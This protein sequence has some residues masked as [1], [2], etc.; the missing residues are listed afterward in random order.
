MTQHTDLPTDPATIETTVPTNDLLVHRAWVRSVARALLGDTPDADDLEQDT[1][2][3]ALR[4][5]PGETRSPRA[6][7]ATVVRNRFRDT[8]RT[9][10][11]RTAREAAV[12]R[13]EAVPS[14]AELA[15]R[16]DE[17]RRVV[18]AVL[19]L[20]ESQRY[21]VLLR[22][23]EGLQPKEIGERLCV[24]ASTVRSR[25]ARAHARLRELLDAEH[26]GDGRSWRRALLPL[27]LPAAGVEADPPRR[28]TR[29][30]AAAV[31]IV[32]AVLLVLGGVAVSLWSSRS[33]AG[34][35]GDDAASTDT[36]PREATD[37]DRP[38]GRARAAGAGPQGDRVGNGGV[39]DVAPE[40]G[41]LSPVD[42]DGSP[43]NEAVVVP[44]DR[45]LHVLVVQDGRPVEG[46]GVDVLHADGRD[47][48][49]ETVLARGITDTEGAVT[50]ERPEGRVREAR[51]VARGNGR[52]AVGPIVVLWDP[53]AATWTLELEAAMELRGLVSDS[54]GV[55]IASA[56]MQLRLAGDRGRVGGLATTGDAEGRFAF[57]LLPRTVLDGATLEIAAEGYVT[58]WTM[59]GERDLQHALFDVTLAPEF[60]VVGRCVDDEGRPVEDAQ[61]SSVYTMD[62]ARSGPDGRF[63]LTKLERLGVPLL[64]EHDAHATAMYRAGAGIRARA[65][66]DRTADLGDVVLSSGVDAVARAVTDDGEPVA[67]AQI[68]LHSIR[69]GQIVA[70]GTTGEDGRVT[71]SHI[72][73]TEHRIVATAHGDAG[74]VGGRQGGISGWTPDGEEVVV[75][76]DGHRSLV[77][78]LVDAETGDPIA[79]SDVSLQI[80]LASTQRDVEHVSWIEDGV[81]IV[82]HRLA[83]S[84]IYAVVVTAT[85][86]EPVRLSDVDIRSDRETVVRARLRAAGE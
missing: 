57:P 61:I 10:S 15:S 1:W 84:G 4:G 2:L 18:R 86:Y 22:W 78:H 56:R 29:W 70:Q 45:S 81:R 68:V 21:I 24:P 73:R 66:A 53:T 79:V 27:L 19:A 43:S 71:L 41:G 55:A 23:F 39:D 72:A 58:A 49:A 17:H 82:R 85:G 12:A 52:A 46:V 16:A 31:S 47:R 67:G 33:G 25:L 9:G 80:S 5:A 69:V 3:R 14:T 26:G 65:D 74:D 36:V 83:A 11:R 37:L 34:A 59:I 13:H 35:R 64:F 75:R 32:V 20:S 62:R 30:P 76:I 6:W 54:G 50:F 63:T 40:P 7:L 8:L 44:R 48:A 60:R 51:F 77:V 42:D 28:R 38:A